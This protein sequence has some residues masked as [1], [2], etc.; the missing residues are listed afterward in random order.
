MGCSGRRCWIMGKGNL[1]DDFGDLGW[2]VDWK[3]RV[4]NVVKRWFG[5]WRGG[6][7]FLLENFL[8]LFGLFFT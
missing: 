1:S 6:G 8:F 7:V 5:F 2:V 3:W 4:R